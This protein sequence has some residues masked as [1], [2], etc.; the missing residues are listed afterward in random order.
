[1]G[2]WTPADSQ[3]LYNV[4]GWS[5]DFFHVGPDGTMQVTPTGDAERT[6]DLYGLVQDLEDRGVQAPIL[7]RFPDIVRTRI[8]TLAGA[9]SDAMTRYGYQGGYRGVYPIKVNQQAQLIEDMIDFLEPH[10]M[11]LEAGSKPELL[12][13]LALL[14]DPKALIICNGYK[15]EEFIETALLGQKLGRNPVL[16]IEKLSEVHTILDTA[17][18]LGERPVLGVRARLAT[19][20]KS[21]WSSSSGD[22]AKFGLPARD[23]VALVRTLRDADY[24]DCLHL[25]HFHIGSQVTAI[26]SFK[27]A[28]REAGRTY[29]ELVR[30]GAPMGLFD[31]G[32]GLGVDYDGS[33]TNFRASRNYSDQEYANDVVAG[34]QAACDAADVPHPDVVTETGRALVAHHSVLI[35]NVLGVSSQSAGGP[36]VDVPDDAPSQLVAMREVYDTL[37]DRN[38]REAWHDAVSLRSEALSAYTLGLVD[39]EQRADVEHLFWQ[40]A[41]RVLRKIQ[42]ATYVPEELQALQV[43]TADTYYCNFSV[44]Q[45]APDAWAIDQLFPVMPIHRLDQEPT[46]RAVLADITC[47]SDG[48][49]DRFIDLRDVKKVLELHPLQDQ[50]YYLGLFM[51]GA[52]Q[53]ILGDLHNLFGDT[54]AVH[55]RLDRE[56]YHIDHV[57]EGDDVTDVLSYVGYASRDLIRRVRESSERAVKAGR[58]SARESR[59]LMRVVQIGLRGYTYLERAEEPVAW[60]QAAKG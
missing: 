57:I 26:R 30:M 33:R 13:C 19:A 20:G 55:V 24:L 11:G 53:E 46:Q 28:V 39:L 8:Q 18:R 48:K 52:Y 10:H 59:A 16:V 58:L 43:L 32:G 9:F 60:G 23:L 4:T 37:S 2:R 45:S 14:S 47:D 22:R 56:G 40:I 1:M 27:E 31:V 12:V 5:N 25:L 50:E 34:I 38:F 54:N 41:G 7:L 42:G 17:R 35:F 36:P 6:I 29:T 21:H 3:A 44:F 51:V 15:D 49:L